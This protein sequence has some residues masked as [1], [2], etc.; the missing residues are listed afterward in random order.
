MKRRISPLPIILL[1]TVSCAEVGGTSSSDLAST[2]APLSEETYYY[3]RCN[4]TD[5]DVNSKTRLVPLGYSSLALAYDVKSDWLMRYGDSCS[6]TATRT[7]DGWGNWHA[8]YQ[9]QFNGVGQ[10]SALGTAH[11]D[12]QTLFLVKYPFLGRYQVNL[13]E[14]ENSF[15]IAAAITPARTQAVIGTTVTF[16]TQL[17]GSNLTYRWQTKYENQDE[18][19]WV[20]VPNA[21][22]PDLQV[23]T[24]NYYMFC[25][26]Y[27]S[28]ISSPHAQTVSA[29]AT[30]VNQ[31][32]PPVFTQ[33][34]PSGLT[35]VAGSTITLKVTTD[36]TASFY[37]WKRDGKPIS[38]GTFGSNSYTSP[39]LTLADD[40][41]MYTVE[42][43]R[44]AGNHQCTQHGVALSGTTTVHVTAQ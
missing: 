30:L 40:G 26:Q 7:L 24:G 28:I 32:P 11:V 8:F 9:S 5:W 38:G 20:D 13:T 44:F 12:A 35:V 41:A 21:T 17:L 18:A 4:A 10:K 33:D 31:L 36:P 22:G 1:L 14:W 3:L 15:N 37:I 16:G 27:R 23:V 29:T 25:A 42:A 34:L 39:A 6:L 19:A 43:V 2:A